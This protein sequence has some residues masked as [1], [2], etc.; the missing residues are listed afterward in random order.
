MKLRAENGR[1]LM[2]MQKL[3]SRTPSYPS[4]PAAFPEILYI[5]MIIGRGLDESSLEE[6]GVSPNKRASL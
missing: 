2:K 1:D 5:G 3:N 6:L 4:F